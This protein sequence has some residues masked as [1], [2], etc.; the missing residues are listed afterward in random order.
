MSLLGSFHSL[1]NE[2]QKAIYFQK[3]AIQK[4][5]FECVFYLNLS[6]TLKKNNQLDKSLFILYFAKILSS[7]DIS[8]DHK[9][10]KLNTS[11]KNFAKSELIYTDLIKDKNINKDIIISYCDN[12]I[13]LKK[14]DEVIS[15]IKKFENK[16]ST[17]DVFQSILGLAYIKK[18]QFDQAKT[19]LLNSIN[20]FI[21]IRF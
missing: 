8:I 18:K 5:P 1:N 14:E 2:L 3:L 21:S 15:F 13:K 16:F 20:T 12:L 11:L 17:D 6:A 19:F 7:Q 9:L 4:A 10:A